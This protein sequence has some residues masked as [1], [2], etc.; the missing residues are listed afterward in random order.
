[1]KRSD[2]GVSESVQWAIILPALLLC[3]LGLVQAGVVMHGRQVM[4]TAAAAAADAEAAAGASN[5]AGAAAARAVAAS[6]GVKDIAV[7]VKTTGD[8]VEVTVSGRVA[9]VVDLGLAE[10]RAHASAPK[11]RVTR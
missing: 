9:T 2:R 5:G 1:M 10:V 3:V 11:E 7:D 8:L 4:H 6:G